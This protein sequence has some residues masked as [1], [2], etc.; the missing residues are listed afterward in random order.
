M[1]LFPVA[2][3]IKRA[4]YP[5]TTSGLIVFWWQRLKAL[6]NVLFRLGIP[7]LLDYLVDLPLYIGDPRGEAIRSIV[8]EVIEANPNSILVGHSLGSLICYDVL[9]QAQARG[10]PLE[11]AARVTLGTPIGWVKSLDDPKYVTVPS[12]SLNVSWL[13]MYY[14]NDPVCLSKELDTTNF[15]EVKNVRLKV[16]IR[17]GL[18]AHTAYWKDRVVA[19]HIR[20]LANG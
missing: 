13:N 16:P 18:A 20:E 3:Q 5:R 8:R 19:Q 14:P 17:I 10:E 12:I 11:V 2:K 7:Q 15:P 4:D 9:C 6:F 1:K